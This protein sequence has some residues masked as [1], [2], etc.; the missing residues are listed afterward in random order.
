MQR[1]IRK[2]LFMS[3]FFIATAEFFQSASDVHQFAFYV[4]LNL[5]K[6]LLV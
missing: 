3:S 2:V 5:R 1:L 6:Q 4:I